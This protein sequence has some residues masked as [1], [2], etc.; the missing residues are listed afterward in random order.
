MPHAVPGTTTSHPERRYDLDWLRVLAFGLLMLYHLGMLYVASWDYHYKSQYLSSSL[1]YLMLLS[2]PWRM[3]LIWL[4]AGFALGTVLKRLPGLRAYL[5]FAGKRTVLLLLPLMVGLWIIVPPQLYAEM[6]QKDGLSLSYWQFYLAFFELDHPLFANYQRGVWP[7]VDVNHLWF[8]RSLW[9]FTL[10]AMLLAPLLYLPGLNRLLTRLFTMPI[11]WF[12]V[13]VGALLLLCRYQ[14]SGDSIR[15][16]Q[17]LL[18]FLLGMALVSVPGFWQQLN[19]CRRPLGWFCL[20]NYLLLCLLYF[21]LQQPAQWPDYQQPMRFALRL[22]FSLQGVAVVAW[23][24]ALAQ[25]YL[26][27]PHRYLNI[28]NR[29]VFPCYLVHQTLL[30]VAALWLTPHA[31]GALAEASLILVFTAAACALLV[32]LGWRLPWCSA[33]IGLN[34]GYPFSQRQRF[35]GYLLGALLVSPLALR[36]LASAI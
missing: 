32:W 8:L 31:V 16:L 24:L 30:I 25:H 27:R 34:T 12:L 22:S 20:L 7:H 33:L 18:F 5:Q 23:L 19:A 2:S 10:L 15:D 3:L 26:N 1:E 28:A 9:R 36:L 13:W 14:F 6:V 35:C 17:G 11:G 29:A 4:I 21:Q